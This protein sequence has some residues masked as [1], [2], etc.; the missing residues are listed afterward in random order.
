MEFTLARNAAFRKSST[1]KRPKGVMGWRIFLK[2]FF[3]FLLL[4][5][6]FLVEISDLWFKIV[7]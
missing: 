3:L 4:F 7:I 6:D 5:S 1:R 2:R